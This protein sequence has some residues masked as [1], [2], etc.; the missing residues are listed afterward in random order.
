M[1]NYIPT[2]A[3]LQKFTYE[4]TSGMDAATNK[5]KSE[6][7]FE[8]MAVRFSRVEGMNW[9]T[10]YDNSISVTPKV[11]A[12]W[13]NSIVFESTDRSEVPEQT[14]TNRMPAML[15]VMFET[16][17]IMAWD[18]RRNR[19]IEAVLIE[20]QLSGATY[21]L[22]RNISEKGR[23]KV[24]YVNLYSFMRNGITEGK[25]LPHIRDFKFNGSRNLV[26]YSGMA[27]D[28][29]MDFV[30]AQIEELGEIFPLSW[31]NTIE[32]LL[33][34]EGSAGNPKEIAIS[35]DL[36]DRTN[37]DKTSIV[38][39]EIAEQMIDEEN[40]ESE[41]EGI[42]IAPNVIM[43]PEGREKAELKLGGN[44]VEV[45]VA[46]EMGFDPEEVVDKET[47]VYAS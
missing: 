31:I 13:L 40:E 29:W 17:S 20:C 4:K 41:I 10:S 8:A 14:A 42:E 43:Y 35:S 32:M 5:W 18:R 15:E 7:I 44:S 11:I 30:E 21:Y 26:L 36:L 47:D 12:D 27:T 34:D 16:E 39:P 24:E 45:R 46:A 25:K 38:Q 9:V 22:G 3:D 37:E 19:M 28:D 23:R 6:V 1:S 2:L 33:V